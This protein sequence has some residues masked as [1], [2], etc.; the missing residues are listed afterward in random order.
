MNEG[1]G[2]SAFAVINL[3]LPVAVLLFVRIFATFSACLLFNK[4]RMP[5]LLRAGL[6]LLLAA[7]LDS[8]GYF[9][10][11][12]INFSSLYYIGLV[13]KEAVVG[14]LLGVLL[15]VPFWLIE[16]CGKVIDQQRGE[17]FAA[18]LNPLTSNTSSSV[19]RLLFQAF[20]GYF[21]AVNGILAYLSII[22][23]SFLL[24]KLGE[25]LPVNPL[26]GYQLYVQMFSAYCY[27]FMLLTLPILIL[28]ILTDLVLGLIGSFIPQLNI[29]VLSIPIKSVMVTAI[30]IFMIS[31]IYH[32]VFAKVFILS[33]KF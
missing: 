21:V 24:I 30:L 8:S 33:Q 15:S 27:S 19:G 7:L 6:S 31:D 11:T 12:D 10:L 2:G 32:D 9:G 1:I 3:H 25:F 28:T 4:S 17:Q 18:M 22:F 16:S 14:Y 5:G 23:K 29:T 13:I 20:I 26:S